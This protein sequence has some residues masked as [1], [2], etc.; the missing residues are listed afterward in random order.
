[1]EKK[2][3]SRVQKLEFL[4]KQTDK[5]HL[6]D[7][8][9]MLDVSEMTLR[10]DLSSDSGNVVLLGGYIVMNPQKSGNHYQIFDQQTRHITEKMWL[11]KLAAGLVKDGDTV[12]FDCGSTIPFIISQIDPQIKFTALCCSIN[13]FMALQDKP[14]CEVILCGG[15][16]SRHNSFL[17]SVQLHSELDAICTTKAFISASGVDIKKGVTCF[18]VDEAKVKQKAMAKTQL[19]ILVFDHHKV[20]KIQQAYIGELAQ[21][22][23]LISNQPLPAGFGEVPKMLVK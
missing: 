12:F 1:M 20:Y 14:H 16:Y 7:A 18:S 15:N 10:R 8:A 3:T 4:L 19:A 11:G 2:Q 6:R 9:Q 17:T 13:S 21:F 23:L 5:I 22:D